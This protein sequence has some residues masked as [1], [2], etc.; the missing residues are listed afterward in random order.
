MANFTLSTDPDDITGTAGDDIISGG[1]GTLQTQD[2]IDGGD[3]R[4]RIKASTD[5]NSTPAPTIENVEILRLET[6][7][8]AFDISNVTGAEV[9]RTFRDSII[10]EGID[11]NDLGIRF[12]ASKVQSGTVNLRFDGGALEGTEDR[13]NLQV[14]RSNVTFTSDSVFDSTA[15]GEQNR[16]EDALRVEEIRIVLSG[17]DKDAQFANQID[18]SDFGTI[19]T[20]ILT[21]F[22]GT[23][24]SKIVV[25]SEDLEEINAI[26]TTGGVTIESVIA[27]DQRVQGGAG[28]D[29]LKTGGGDDE[30]RGKDGDDMLTAGEGDNTV[31]GGAGNDTIKTE[32]G[33]DVIV[34]GTG[35]D[36]ID[37]GSGDD[38]VLGNDGDDTINAGGGDDRIVGG[39]GADMID[40][41]NGN[42]TIRDDGGNDTVRGGSGNDTLFMGAGD[43][44]VFGEG[45]RDLF[46]FRGND[47]GSDTVE[48]FQLT[49]NDATNDR[50]FFDFDGTV[51]QLDTQDEFERFYDQNESTGRVTVDANADT[52]TIVADGGTIEL[53]VSD[54]DF[55]LA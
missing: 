7:G 30:L 10:V 8:Q 44:T 14:F 40:G 9:L 26:R 42:D 15:D 46:F 11:A 22:P 25:G 27:G 29:D 41:G 1:I 37:A 23:G 12:A 4:D 35:N 43:D 18:I 24:P 36:T 19:T 28:D 38:R 50:V 33:A 2:V 53:N 3:G 6:G 20:L 31:V 52:I 5:R 54:A 48:D 49:S 47:L 32:S 16:T 55:L 34:G 17:T 45:G 51:Q 13:L 39:N 21:E